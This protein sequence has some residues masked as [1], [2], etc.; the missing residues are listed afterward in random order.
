MGNKEGR[1]TPIIEYEGSNSRSQ[2]PTIDNELNKKKPVDMNNG[3]VVL[4]RTQVV[5]KEVNSVQ[6][7]AMQQVKTIKTNTMANAQLQQAKIV[8]TNTVVIKP[9]NISYKSVVR[10]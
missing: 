2:T 1:N 10:T 5:E 6:V 9:M 3:R 8:K 7:P 4:G